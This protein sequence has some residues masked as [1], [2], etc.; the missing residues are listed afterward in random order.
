MRGFD[1]FCFYMLCLGGLIFW[2][3]LPYAIFGGLCR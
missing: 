3:L 1:E 2:L